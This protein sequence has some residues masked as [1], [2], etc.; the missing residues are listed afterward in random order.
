MRWIAGLVAWLAWLALGTSLGVAQTIDSPYQRAQF[1]SKGVQPI[2]DGRDVEA[3][4]C[5]NSTQRPFDIGRLYVASDSANLY[6]G[7]EQHSACVCSVEVWI[8]INTGPGGSASNPLGRQVDW[9]QAPELPDRY[10]YD[11]VPL[12]LAG[13]AGN[14][15]A[16][17]AAD[18]AGGWTKL[19]D[20]GG[21]SDQLEIR[22][23]DGFHG[24]KMSFERLGITCETTIGVEVF[25]T[26]PGT[27]KPALDMV[28]NDSQQRSTPAG[29]LYDTPPA[30]AAPPSRPTA[31]LSHIRACNAT[32]V[33]KATWGNVRMLYR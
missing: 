15:E 12:F 27:T 23:S 9:S 20:Q 22:D 2:E 31:Y 4:G 28:I 33:K 13:C 24:M 26:L 8:A 19:P 14:V 29:T 3:F 21:G 10:I 25:T 32:T 30:G 6:I 18:G 16:L 17:Y 7:F 5:S 11:A 1:E